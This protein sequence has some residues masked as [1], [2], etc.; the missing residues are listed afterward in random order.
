MAVYFFILNLISNLSFCIYDRSPWAIVCM[1]GFAALV[2]YV[3]SLIVA[4]WKNRA[5]KNS[6][7]IVFSSI[8]I[9]LIAVD[10]FLVFLFGKVCNQ[11]VIDILAETNAEQTNDF[12]QSYI[13]FPN[14][15]ALLFSIS[16]IIGLAL[17]LN[18]W[19]KI[20]VVKYL[21]RSLALIGGIG[22]LVSGY[23]FVRYGDGFSIPQY[24]AP[25]R[26][27]WSLR[28]LIQRYNSIRN[29]NLV[30]QKVTGSCDL[31]N[32]PTI[33]VVIGE[34][35]SAYHCSLYG[36]EKETFPL[37]KQREENGNL[38][39][40]Q[41]VVCIA[42]A[43]HRNMK[44]IF[45]LGNGDSDFDTKPLFPAVFKNV[46]YKTELLDNQYFF[47]QGVT[48]LTDRELSSKLFDE[49]NE[50]G[51]TYDGDMID[52]LLELHSP[53]LYI[54]HLWGQHYTYAHRYPDSF[55]KFNES[56]YG[57]M[58]HGDIVA[59]Y[60]NANLYNDY[61]VD[62]IIKR[63]ESDDALLVYFSDHG[64]EVYEQGFM[65]HGTSLTSKDFRYQLRVPM[66]IWMS[67]KFMQKRGNVASTIKERV[68]AP[69][70]T[71][72]VSH[73]LLDVAGIDTEAFD[74]TRSFIH[75][76]YDTSR[77]RLVMGNWD[78]DKHLEDLK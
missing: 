21:I 22:I 76:R 59:H 41:D 6:T 4:A 44:A 64:E 63:F 53:A 65:G 34:S 23:G 69:L 71:S 57:G 78:Y 37:L 75:E 18:R 36:Y 29:L 47:G 7:I 38:C 5:W 33:I 26:V 28:T 40:M 72:D 2:A 15:L 55:H 12:I 67:D 20:K 39:V 35:F 68:K 42:D 66:L 11:D 60:D 70:M 61:V 3:E 27:V 49:R 77:P 31:T 32:A 9:I 45:S 62:E 50:E 14:I 43:T 13:S 24:A 30:C 58:E 17:F 56:D 52:D 19:S 74:A 25:A 1:I 10:Y 16:L 54:F 46:G 73:F 51:Y 48:F 8:H